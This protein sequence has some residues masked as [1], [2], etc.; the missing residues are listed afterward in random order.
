MKIIDYL[1]KHNIQYFPIN[2]SIADGKKTL[3]PYIENHQMPKQ[4]D[5]EQLTQNELNNRLLF[6]YNYKHIAID[7]RFIQQ[8]DI[9]SENARDI[10]IPIT[11]E[12][13][14]FLSSSKKLPHIFVNL[15]NKE[16]FG[17]RF[18]W[19]EID[20]KVE[21]LNGQW[22]WC[23]IDAEI[24]NYGNEIRDLNIVKPVEI[25]KHNDYTFEYTNQHINVLLE[26]IDK[27]FID[28]YNVWW[29]IGC[30]LFH[31][32]YPFEV[33]DNWSKKGSKYG[34]TKKLWENLSKSNNDTIKLGT[35]CY[36]A[37]QSNQ[38]LF[39]II[40]EKLPKK[41]QIEIFKKF[42]E[43]EALPTL[44]HSIVSDIFYER[45]N[46]RYA[47]SR[48]F[49]YRLSPGGIYEKLNY[50]ADTI[51]SKD[52]LVYV[53]SFL[54][55]ILPII[56]SSE[57]KKRLWKSYTLLENQSF[58]KNCVDF[59]RKRFLNEKLEQELDLNEHLVGFSNGVYNLETFEFRK[60]TIED[61]VSITTGY[62]YIDTEL[63]HEDINF[64]DTLIDTWFE[65]TETSYWFKKHIA[66]C[67]QPGN[68]EEKIYF[69][70]GSG[71]NGKGT[72]DTL[73]RETLGG[74]YT[75]LDNAFF[76]I[77]KKNSN[78]AEPELIKLKNKR[79]TMTT[80][81][82]GE[83]KYISEKFKKIS[84]GDL[85]SCRQLYSNHVEEF[86]PT[87]KSI[88][89]TN[90]LPQFT[91]VDDGLLNR[92]SV[93]K[94]PYKFLDI[95]NFTKDK[96]HKPCDENLKAL[97][98]VKKIYFFNYLIKYYKAYLS[99]GLTN[100]P[101]SIS[102][103]IEEYKDNIDTVKTFIKHAFIK[104]DVDTDRIPLEEMLQY[105]NKWSTEHLVIVLF[106]K[107]INNHIKTEKKRING[108]QLTCICGYKWNIEFK[109]DYSNCDIQDF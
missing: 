104:T 44:S 6:A 14:Y 19:D 63:S 94:F 107:R 29:K 97:L 51:I 101:K 109:N 26:I 83:I 39:N 10:F 36:Y 2:V 25:I 96:F 108:R 74:Y 32:G 33:F 72:I 87:F 62:E 70:V 4:T 37:K 84:G 45:Y 68:K 50:D 42:I 95:N 56:T 9:D 8:I 46:Y 60:G 22:S 47:F 53:Q 77:Y 27:K 85:I 38:I 91:E 100:L 98:K 78:Q 3:L 15:L 66:S 57:Q 102:N 7:T 105:Y 55:N 31:C 92:I 21:I 40:K 24:I 43:N 58:L 48:N 65:D 67:I 35:I 41:S 18:T 13:P 75:D 59:S 93:V 28:D 90:H 20:S 81:T 73:L 71:R 16:H 54:L 103:S 69:W 80:E 86:V 34:G 17:K 82:S 12:Q 61:R 5:F 89:Q 11:D 88:I 1:K 79:I 106:S 99:E 30:A 76:T 23:D 49:W 64:F 52:I